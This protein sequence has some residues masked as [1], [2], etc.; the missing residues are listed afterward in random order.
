MR[1][2]LAVERCGEVAA[3]PAEQLALVRA[4]AV[5][6][7]FVEALEEA[8]V[9][10]RATDHDSAEQARHDAGADEVG[11]VRRK[12]LANGVADRRRGEHDRQVHAGHDDR[13]PDRGAKT[14]AQG[15]PKDDEAVEQVR[16]DRRAR[17]VD[18]HRDGSHVERRADDADL[19]RR[20]PREQQ[21]NDEDRERHHPEQREEHRQRPNLL[22]EDAE[23]ERSDQHHPEA[24]PHELT[25]LRPHLGLEMTLELLASSRG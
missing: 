5:A 19:A 4:L 3:E 10:G 15:R 6:L 21:R 16:V 24:D 23:E 11:D 7:L 20:E 1:R 17:H 8:R 2:R 22:P 12:E 25:L 14:E 9:V 18:G 13:R